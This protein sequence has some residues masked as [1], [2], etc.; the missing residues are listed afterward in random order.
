MQLRTHMEIDS[1]L[2]AMFT[3]EVEY[4]IHF[5]ACDRPVLISRASFTNVI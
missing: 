4:D 5:L 2:P 3:N 1:R